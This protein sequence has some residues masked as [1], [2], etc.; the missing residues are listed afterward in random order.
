MSLRLFFSYS[1]K[2]EELRNQLAAH[3][4][5]LEKLGFISPWH[6]R[7]IGAGNEWSREINEHLCAAEIVL[8]L[9]SPDFL[10]SSY[11]FGVE[12]ELAL[13]RHSAHQ[14]VVI[15]VI[16]RPCDWAGAPF[17]HIQALPRDARPIT[18]WP[19]RDEAFTDVA[20]AI[21]ETALR[22][23]QPMPGPHPSAFQPLLSQDLVRSR[24]LDAAMPA[25][26]VEQRATELSVLIRLPTS[27]GLQGL[28]EQDDEA[29]ARPE[30]VRS[31]PFEVC[32]PLGPTGFPEP[33]EVAIDVTAPDF[34]PPQ[35]R[36]RVMVPVNADSEVCSFLL[37]PMRYGTLTVIIELTWKD[38]ARGSRRLR[39]T[40]VSES[41][42]TETALRL[43]HMALAVTDRTRVL[44]AAAGAVATNNEYTVTA[45]PPTAM[46]AGPFEQTATF[47]V[48]QT[49]LQQSAAAPP[50]QYNHPRPETSRPRA[51]SKV[52]VLF[53]VLA[54]L[55]VV[56][57][58]ALT[59]FR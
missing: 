59:L 9:I 24:V 50:P 8:L 34:M 44:G 36:K 51:T 29:E 20:K 27:P 13:Q 3:L 23:Q 4:A 15:P 49:G 26:I 58:A 41:Q 56:L 52:W 12:M 22:F 5:V 42:K 10:A 35:Q 57:I 1:H 47:A 32:F 33:L 6:D 46:G 14:A 2:D 53:L 48:P 25:Q 43:V 21:R 39:T 30:D 17:A 16:L 31:K 38:V 28:L 40:C 45:L 11:C 37:T 55:T 18:L 7:C 54:V 19:N